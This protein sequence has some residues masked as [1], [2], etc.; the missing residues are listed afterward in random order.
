MHEQSQTEKEC[1]LM[2]KLCNLMEGM[3]TP[4]L[5]FNM[6]TPEICVVCSSVDNAMRCRP[7]CLGLALHHTDS[8]YCYQAQGSLPLFADASKME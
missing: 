8:A 4:P 3:L 2:V 5:I 6:S 1:G 7:V